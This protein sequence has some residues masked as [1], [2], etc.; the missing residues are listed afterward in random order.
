MTATKKSCSFLLIFLVASSLLF[1]QTASAMA[2]PSTPELTA[3]YSDYS[4]D[5]PLT[6][7][8]ETNPYTGKQETISEGGYYVENKTIEL[9]IKNPPYNERDYLCYNVRV[10]GH[11]TQ[12]WT[13][14]YGTE[15]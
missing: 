1:L 10:K 14:L 12:N 5:V 4:Y 2:K 3:K 11:F 8:T 7:K 13:T 9:I 15:G 6:D